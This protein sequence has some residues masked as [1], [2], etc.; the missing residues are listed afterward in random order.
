[1]KTSAYVFFVAALIAVAFAVVSGILAAG[2]AVLC[3]SLVAIRQNPEEAATLIILFGSF[4]RY[5]YI[6]AIVFAAVSGSL[7]LA[8]RKFSPSSK[9]CWP[10]T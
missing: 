10:T 6:T 8:G 5:G 2:S 9:R 4:V 3:F 1:M 7:S